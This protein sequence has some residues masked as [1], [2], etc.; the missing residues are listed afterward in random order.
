MGEKLEIRYHTEFFKRRVYAGFSRKE[1]SVATKIGISTLTNIELGKQ[2]PKY[3]QLSKLAAFY[4]I[5]INQ[6]IPCEHLRCSQ[7]WEKMI[8]P[9]HIIY[10]KND[11]YI[12]SDCKKHRSNR[13]YVLKKGVCNDKKQC[14]SIK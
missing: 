3:K 2:I 8:W 13:D 4:G 7:C 14:V 5:S 1:V 9:L 6:I 10:E 12:C 11:I